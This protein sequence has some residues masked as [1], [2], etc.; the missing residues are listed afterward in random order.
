MSVYP[1]HSNRFFVKI[2]GWIVSG[3]AAGYNRKT[4]RKRI[5]FISKRLLVIS[6]LL[7]YNL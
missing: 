3:I 6:N 1:I 4:D 7:D 5:F 2:V